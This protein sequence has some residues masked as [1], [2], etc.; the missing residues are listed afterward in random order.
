MRGKVELAKL[1]LCVNMETF[2]EAQYRLDFHSVHSLHFR[3]GELRERVTS[4]KRPIIC[5][6]FLTMRDE[7]FPQGLKESK[8]SRWWLRAPF[9]RSWNRSTKAALMALRAEAAA[10]LVHAMLLR[11]QALLLPVKTL[12]M[13]GY[14]VLHS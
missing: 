6:A 14:S 5:Q 1:Q 3:I 4:S 2:G 13:N 7:P 12:V 9:S 10:A 11:V 8:R